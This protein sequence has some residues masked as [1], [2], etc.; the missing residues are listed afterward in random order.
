MA[1]QLSLSLCA[2]NSG[3]DVDVTAREQVVI[4]LGPITLDRFLSPRGGGVRNSTQISTKYTYHIRR[5]ETNKLILVLQ[6]SK[7][8]LRARYLT[9]CILFTNDIS[10]TFKMVIPPALQVTGLFRDIFNNFLGV[11]H[12]PILITMHS[13]FM[14]HMC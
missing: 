3:V 4:T 8:E 1:Y 11:S 13:Q 14:L 12:G 6:S 5:G 10:C 9:S 2:C 7:C